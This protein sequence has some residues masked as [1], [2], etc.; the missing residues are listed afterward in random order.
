MENHW[1]DKG[2]L[3]EPV[4]K[5]GRLERK[6]LLYV[7]WNY[8]VLVLVYFEIILD[9][10]AINAEVYSGQLINMYKVIS[11]KYPGL[12]NRKPV[13][14]QQENIKPH[15]AKVTRNK[16]EELGSFK[17]LLHPAFSP[18]LAPS[19]Y[20][21]FRSMAKFLR[22]KKFESKGDVANAVR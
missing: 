1:L 3:P 7:W 21:L 11:E 20:Y 14:L 15:T 2:K 18:D 19:D 12:V 4:A 9:G 10:R 13:L 22:G 16:I 6:V 8:E 17:L 5:R